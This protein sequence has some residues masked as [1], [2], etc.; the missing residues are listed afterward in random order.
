MKHDLI[1]DDPGVFV[2]QCSRAIT[3]GLITMSLVDHRHFEPM[4][5]STASQE[6]FQPHK[7]L[8]NTLPRASSTV[9]SCSRCFLHVSCVVVCLGQRC[10]GH[11][12]HFSCAQ[13]L[14]CDVMCSKTPKWPHHVRFEVPA[15]SARWPRAQKERP[16]R[17][18]RSGETC[19]GAADDS[20]RP[21]WLVDRVQRRAAS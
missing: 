3:V 14:S 20:C 16:D 7:T 1:Q 21:S 15:R 2:Q 10:H 12:S 6:I 19:H 8:Q 5:S 13:M 18:G 9:S 11:F 17:A 4:R